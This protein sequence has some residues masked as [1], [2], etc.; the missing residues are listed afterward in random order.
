M[1]SSLVR[2]VVLIPSVCS[3]LVIPTAAF[4]A[5][6]ERPQAA[7]ADMS[8]EQLMQVQTVTSASRFEQSASDA[9]SAVSILTSQDIREYGWR[10]LA[11]ALASL[12]GLYVSSDRNYSY[13]GARGFLRP[14]DYD[15]RFLLMIDGI[16]TNDNVFD[17]ALIGT[18]GLLDMDL[19]ER[20]EYVP[21]PGAAVY[22]SN[23]IFGV[24]N[25]ITKSGSALA[26]VQAAQ[27]FGSRGE[28]RSRV[29]YGWHAQNGSDVV[30]SASGYHRRG[31]DVYFPE[32]DTPDHDN[33][34]ARGLDWDRAENLFAKLHLGGFTFTAGY[35]ARTKGVPT[36]SFGSVFNAPDRTRD[37][38]TFANLGYES[39]LG[40][41]LRLS[42]N[43]FWGRED[44]LGIAMYPN[45]DGTA[46]RDFDGAHGAWYGASGQLTYTGMSDHKILVGSD[47]Q[48][49]RRRDQF[50]F[51]VAPYKVLLNDRRSGGRV[52][53]FLE[54]EWHVAASTILNAGLRYDYDSEASGRFSPRVALIQTLTSEDTVKA[55]HGKA[56]RTPNAYEQYYAIVRTG[57]QEAIPVLRPEDIHTS[58]LV[59]E[60]ALDAYGKISM[61]LFSYRMHDLITQAT[62]TVNGSLRVINT[63]RT[64]AHGVELAGERSFSSGV[65]VRANY[66]FQRAD[67]GNGADLINSPHHLLHGGVSVP[68]ASVDARIGAELQC[69]SRRLSD[70]EEVAGYCGANLVL[71]SYHKLHG[72]DWSLGLYNTLDR[73]YDDPSGPA[74]VQERIPRQGRTVVGKLIYGF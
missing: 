12:P 67:S 69:V 47:V 64:R 9:P 59:W 41:D 38:E 30:L 31:D 18:E 46:H 58:E 63:D 36:A 5:S 7:L 15:S 20:I 22:G 52:A 57:G 40:S 60:H 43:L 74:F 49:N 19:V 28:R 34:L 62:D 68:L 3:S 73:A 51:N 56:F 17:E 44:Y 2:L 4:A 33:G 54:D 1:K 71:S 23:A 26:G 25:V 39:K 48:R 55:I 70:D 6:D 14:G 72:L 32:F 27:S 16:R 24:I 45:D 35:V 8:L 50:N 11:D 65:R 21:G 53:A 13:L 29:S 42:T 61:S 10:T 37:A 66:S